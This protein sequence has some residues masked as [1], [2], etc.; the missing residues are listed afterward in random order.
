MSL[1]N[2]SFHIPVMG[3][4]YT[5]NTPVKVAPYGIASVVSIVEDNLLERMR[6]YYYNQLNEMYIPI[7]TIDLDHRAKRI[8]DYLNL[9][10]RLVQDKVESMK[11]K[12][13]EKGQE[14]VKYFEMLPEESKMKKLYNTMLEVKDAYQKEELQQKLRSLIMPGSIDVNIM[15]KVDRDCYDK[16]GVIIAN[17]SDALTAIRGYATSNLTNSAVVLSA[18]MNPR[19]YN[20]LENFDQ[21]RVM[22]NGIFEK[23][24]II[25]VSDFRS[26]L[27]QGK[28]LAKKGLWVSEFRVESSLNCGGHAF[29]TDGILLGPIL[30]EFK[31]KKTEIANELFALYTKAL[32]EKELAIP[33]QI[34][35]IK[36]TVQGGIGTAIEDSF[37]RNYYEMDG[38]GWGTPFLL[39]PEATIVDDDTINKLCN[40]KDDDIILSKNSPLGVRFNY[41]KGNSGEVEKLERIDNEKPGSFCTERFLQNNTEFTELPICTASTKY[42]KLKIEQLANAGLSE[43]EFEQ[44][45]KWVLSK[46]CLCLGLSNAATHCGITHPIAKA[47][48]GVTICP[49]P[50]IAYF[51]KVVSLQTM[52]DH[53]YGRTNIMEANNRPNMFAKEIEL[54]ANYYE[55]LVKDSL[56]KEDTKQ[57][58]QLAAFYKNLLE[59]I[60]Y[61]RSLI[62]SKKFFEQQ[63]FAEQL[64]H[65]EEKIVGIANMAEQAVLLV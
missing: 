2:H 48:T 22:N 28:Y 59:G 61:Y 19:L 64:T 53:I 63:I 14:I 46:E 43:E 58:K 3:L 32:Q 1:S 33:T 52:V 54:Y 4:A 25:K 10:N 44:Q 17:G 42:Q 13:F 27:I 5:V 36:Y 45:K 11:S 15:T 20:Y 30:E 24:I 38:T 51:N 57:R 7:P 23:K 41:L 8:T 47:A 37:L 34:P 39:V 65:L 6:E 55:E 40:A 62:N 50:N 16:E 12:A 60:H 9:M 49:G 21:F 56:G 26:A 31:T 29:A 18:G 35:A